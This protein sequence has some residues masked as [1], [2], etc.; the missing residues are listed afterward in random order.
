MKPIAS[1][2]C[3]AVLAAATVQAERIRWFCPAASVNHDST[4]AAMDAGFQF[5]LG[6]F[7]AGFA[8][9]AGNRHAW[10]AHWNAAQT[11]AYVPA[12][13]STGT[14]LAEFDNDDP[15]P[16]GTPGW[17]LGR[18]WTATGSEWILF[19]H[20]DWT[21]PEAPSGL[22]DPEDLV[23]WN[24]ADADIVL[25]GVIDG[26]GSPFL[27]MSERV[28]SYAQWQAAELAGESLDGAGDDPDLDGIEN[29]IEFFCGTDPGDGTSIPSAEIAFTGPGGPFLRAIYPAHP[30]S[31]A[32]A[33]VEASG[34]L[35]AWSSAGVSLEWAAGTLVATD[36]VAA[37]PGGRRFLRLR[38]ELP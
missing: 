23:L 4:G 36:S 11:T 19:R 7:D 24:A 5:E 2:C 31:L 21:W 37:V 1:W 25:A 9:T 6:V 20:S 13:G 34:N 15:F 14:F 18:R 32:V 26:D 33:T 12:A 16:L 38:V 28:R 17:I 8:P 10:L 3:A 30:G 27:M 35:S 22:F 29:V